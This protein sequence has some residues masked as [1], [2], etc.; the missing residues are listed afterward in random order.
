MK[1][2]M[3]VFST[4]L[5]LARLK[6]AYFLYG[7]V[8]VVCAL[9]TAVQ[10]IAREHCAAFNGYDFF[11]T[12][13]EDEV[14]LCIDAGA[15]IAARDDEGATPLHYAASLGTEGMI[16]ALLA[17]GAHL[18][19][20]T[21]ED[22]RTPLHWAVLHGMVENT[23][24][25][26]ES[27]AS[28][29]TRTLHGLT[30]LHD[31][32][33]GRDAKL[34]VAALMAAGADVEARA[35][36]GWTPLH[37]AGAAGTPQASEA[38]SVLLAA[39]AEIDSR[40]TRGETPLHVAAREGMSHTAD[41]LLTGGADPNARDRN[42]WIPLHL[43]AKSS[44]YAG[45][46]VIDALLD[47]GSEFSTRDGAGMTP[48]HWAASRNVDNEVIEALLAAGADPNARADLALS[49]VLDEMMA[50]NED[51]RV[52][53][54]VRDAAAD[55]E[56]QGELGWSPLHLAGAYNRNLSVIKALLDAGAE[57]E[58]RSEGLTPLHVA[59]SY[60]ASPAIVVALL[61][62]GAHT[63]AR[64]G[65]GRTPLHLAAQSN[66][67]SAVIAALLDAGAD[68]RAM[69]DADSLPWDY[70][71]ERSELSESSAYWRLHEARF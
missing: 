2:L 21:S 64:D 26:L 6:F 37:E 62:A 10:P 14:R 1:S 39:G 63:G 49:V 50:G 65:Q 16:V 7:C 24:T 71:R 31:A 67:N 32:V 28:V 45:P 27:G 46:G 42:G 60:N 18:H 69:D 47:A 4:T 29:E 54:L 13:T 9:H 22:A 3:V 58:A 48:L 40:T 66:E 5:E 8:F 30:P 56:V 36:N 19:A 57:L 15:N 12:A 55:A 35:A 34:K 51:P 20:V 17:A 44:G 23:V 59:A 68:P 33:R 61:D 11:S 52:I 53:D 43:A 70:V 38:I 25:L 41:A